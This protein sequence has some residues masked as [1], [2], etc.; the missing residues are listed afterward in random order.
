MLRNLWANHN[1]TKQTSKQP[2]DVLI[3][4]EAGQ[5]FDVECWGAISYS[6]NLVVVGDNKQLA[7]FCVDNSV[8]KCF[9]TS[10]VLS[11]MDRAIESD[12]KAQKRNASNQNLTLNTSISCSWLD[13]QYRFNNEI[14]KWPNQKLYENRLKAGSENVNSKF[15]NLNPVTIYNVKKSINEHLNEE[16]SYANVAEA[17]VLMEYL[18]RL[19]V[20]YS[21][22]STASCKSSSKS[23]SKQE[24]NPSD[25][26][27]ICAY[28]GQKRLIQTKINKKYPKNASKIS[29]QI[30]VDTVDAFQGSEKKIILISLVR[31]NEDKQIGF[32]GDIRRFNVAVTRAQW[33][34]ALF[35]NVE[36]FRDCKFWDFFEVHKGNIVKVKVGSCGRKFPVAP[37][38]SVLGKKSLI[39]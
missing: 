29:S 18:D 31:S 21:S 4:D 9:Q 32:V 16:K 17:E 39:N 19:L 37:T 25:I 8:K 15:K 6:K 7:P 10:R 38:T 13:I 24:L 33:H 22:L 1:G 2:F 36:T 35:C 30:S 28:A 3:I 14:M 26:G 34:L 27:I 23:K 11:I 5:N 12:R 20:Q